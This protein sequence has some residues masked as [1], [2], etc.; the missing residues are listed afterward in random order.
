M[1]Y[2]A[3]SRC[4]SALMF[5]LGCCAFAVLSALGPG[6][7]ATEV[8]LTQ[9][10]EFHIST[11]ALAPA[12]LQFSEQAHIQIATSG[13][14]VGGIQTPGVSG[15]WP[16]GVAL[17]RLLAG[18]GFAFRVSGAN[19]IAVLPK[20]N[21]VATTSNIAFHTNGDELF[22]PRV[23]QISISDSTQGTPSRTAVPAPGAATQAE[24]PAGAL[25]EIVV[26]ARKREEN[27]QDVPLSLTVLDAAVLSKIGFN[28]IADIKEKVAALDITP[29]NNSPSELAVFIRGIGATDDEQLS[30]DNGVGVYLDDVY[31]GHGMMLASQLLDI[32]RIEVLPGP[33]GTLYGRNTVGGA[34][35]F[36]SE[37]PTGV[38][39]VKDSLDVGNYGYVNEYVSLN[40]PKTADISVKLSGLISHIDGWVKNTGA[41]GDF[42]RKDTTGG[43]AAFRWTPAENLTVDYVIDRNDSHGTPD[44]LQYQYTDNYF[45]LYVRPAVSDRQDHTWRPVNLPQNDWFLGTGNSL[46]VAWDITQ[47]VSLKSIS[48][49][50]DFNAGFFNDT[51]E[52]FNFAYVQAITTKQHQFSQELLLTGSTAE[53]QVN[54]HLGLFYFTEGGFQYSYLANDFATLTAAVPYVPPTLA[55]VD[56]NCV[57]VIHNWSK[58]VYGEVTW[59]LPILDR[60]LSIDAGGRNS[61]DTRGVSR[62]RPNSVA[63]IPVYDANEASYSSFDPAVTIDYKLTPAAHIY[64]KVAKA[65][66][67][68]GFDAFN[69]DYA[70]AFG[71]EHVTSYEVGVKSEW[72]QRRLL[73]NGDVF[74]ERYRDI[75]ELFYD[76]VFNGGAQETVNAGRATLKGVEAQI[77]VVPIAALDVNLLIT[78]L[79]TEAT[80]T[81]PYNGVT[82][83]GGLPNSPKW[84]GSLSANYTFAPVRLGQFSAFALYSYNARQLLIGEPQLDYRPPYPL[85]DARISL[86]DID[87]G[88]GKLEVSAWGKNLTDKA[89][90]TFRQYGG[91]QFGLPRNYGVNFTYKFRG[92]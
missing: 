70:H 53:S 85:L 25:E 11:Q 91:V 18:T 39:D 57:C 55:D 31:V 68:G 58:A 79:E 48:A 41:A 16:I 76:P 78:H 21:L 29:D 62:Y 81:D 64:G 86:S 61:S 32:E 92:A 67:A 15:V 27:A 37:K 46:T 10:V 20:K 30:R 87:L 63:P 66:Q 88:S 50:R 13:I 40:L 74:D 26:T 82:T 19:S 9:P 43:R 12:L 60:R 5:G 17:E 89:Y 23:V 45:G 59:V 52:G 7:R 80:V 54:Y 65:Y 73:L 22:E 83:T 24:R 2:S 49:Y 4:R 8:N 56:L 72:L 77:E 38:F 44:Y 33:Q 3:L 90:Q 34:V 1:Q 75:Q 36:I 14:E 69:N 42:G 84:K 35:K 28:S 47:H 71:P 6:A 51:V